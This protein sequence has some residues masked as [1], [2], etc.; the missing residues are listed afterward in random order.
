MS[1]L[2]LLLLHSC[3]CPT[4]DGPPFGDGFR[5]PPPLPAASKTS[6]ASAKISKPKEANLHV[7][8]ER[9]TTTDWIHQ[10]LSLYSTLLCFVCSALWESKRDFVLVHSLVLVEMRAGFGWKKRKVRGGREEEV[11]GEVKKLTTRRWPVVWSDVWWAMNRYEERKKNN[12][13]V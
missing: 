7:R 12:H 8:K 10:Q 2:L 4:F 1:L 9:K 5:K 13:Q 3:Q 6:R 11:E